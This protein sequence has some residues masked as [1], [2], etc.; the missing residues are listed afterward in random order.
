MRAA[1]CGSGSAGWITDLEHD[2][3]LAPARLAVSA[4]SAYDRWDRL[5]GEAEF[6]L[7]VAP[8]LVAINTLAYIKGWIDVFDILLLLIPIVTLLA[9][10]LINLQ[11]AREQLEVAIDAGV[12]ESVAL[13]KLLASRESLR[14]PSGG[15]RIRSALSTL[16]PYAGAG[17][18]KAPSLAAGEMLRTRAI[19]GA[20]APRLMSARTCDSRAVSRPG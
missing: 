9:L 18:T 14:Q 11:R 12:V 20:D 3:K 4:P 16:R 2:L 10:G 8:P 1:L 19:S 5:V 7:A 13:G 15:R 6:R 17:Q